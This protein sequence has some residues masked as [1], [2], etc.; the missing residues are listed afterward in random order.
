MI[1]GKEMGNVLKRIEKEVEKME[2]KDW[3]EKPRQ[4]SEKAQNIR[5]LIGKTFVIKSFEEKAGKAAEK[6]YTYAIVKTD[7]GT[8]RTASAVLVKQLNQMKED[9]QKGVGVRVKIVYRKNYLTF[10]SP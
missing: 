2:T 4:E 5:E 9:L 10:D 1:V 6:V 7:L 8:F 3:K